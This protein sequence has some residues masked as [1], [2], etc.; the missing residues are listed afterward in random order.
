MESI[1]DGQP[2]EQL[3]ASILQSRKSAERI[4][5]SF[6]LDE[7]TEATKRQLSLPLKAFE[8][9]QASI[10][11]GRRIQEL[12]SRYRRTMRIASSEDA[13]KYC[14][15][16]FT[17]LIQDARREEFHIVTLTTKNSVIDTHQ[18]S[19]GTLDSSLVHPREVFRPAIRDAASAILL[20]H[21]HPSG[22]PT[23]SKE[24]FAVTKRLIEV[25]EVIGIEV[26]DHIVMGKDGC[27]STAEMT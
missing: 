3:L 17:R 13:M 7:I 19:V 4:A 12:K 21:N 9:L 16:R 27:V 25:G 5:S 26:L 22:D 10:E 6:S 2:L 8:R 14:Q 20:A 18:I 11:L 15:N 24:D 1:H 23:P